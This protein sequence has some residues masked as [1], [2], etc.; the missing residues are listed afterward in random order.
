MLD[1]VLGQ[2][3]GAAV[4]RR[5]VKEG[6]QPDGKEMFICSLVCGVMYVMATA[7]TTCDDHWA[8]AYERQTQKPSRT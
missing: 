6:T 7:V 4:P 2:T 5:F 3:S 1:Q 8:E